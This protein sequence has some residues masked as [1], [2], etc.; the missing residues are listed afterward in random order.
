[1]KHENVVMNGL[2]DTTDYDELSYE[3]AKQALFAAEDLI[4]EIFLLAGVAPDNI[5]HMLHLWAGRVPL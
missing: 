3:K 4:G 1:M 2:A 5:R